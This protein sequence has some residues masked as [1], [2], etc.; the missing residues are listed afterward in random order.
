[1]LAERPGLLAVVV[2]MLQLLPRTASDEGRQLLIFT[3]ATERTEGYD[4]FQ[5]SL[6]LQG[7]ELVTLGTGHKDT[8]STNTPNMVVKST[9]RL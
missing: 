3:V 9:G 6:Q 2:V 4:R 7:L 8:K 1:M 5:R